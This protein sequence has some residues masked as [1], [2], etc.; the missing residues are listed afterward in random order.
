MQ[1][2]KVK[3]HLS[4]TVKYGFHCTDL[5]EACNC[6]ATFCNVYQFYQTL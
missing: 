3:L 4:T 2:I 5:H 1:N 6:C